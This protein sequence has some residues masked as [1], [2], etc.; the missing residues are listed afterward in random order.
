MSPKI[1]PL[2][3]ISVLGDGFY[4]LGQTTVVALLSLVGRSAVRGKQDKPGLQLSAREE[5][6]Y[7]HLFLCFFDKLA[8][9]FCHLRTS[10][11]PQNRQFPYT[12]LI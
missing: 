9:V 12:G 6:P 3:A 1:T 4:G 11:S 7:C 10:Q 5:G 2:T 8:E